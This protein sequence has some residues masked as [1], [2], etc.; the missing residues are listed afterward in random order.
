MYHNVCMYVR[1]CTTRTHNVGKVVIHPTNL[2]HGFGR[3]QDEQQLTIKQ[4]NQDRGRWYSKHDI[5]S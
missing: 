1:T 5:H 4:Y 3:K 2:R